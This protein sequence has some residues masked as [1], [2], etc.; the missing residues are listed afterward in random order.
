VY[1]CCRKDN[2]ASDSIGVI[3]LVAVT[4]LLA[5]LVLLMINV[6][7]FAWSMETEIPE[8]FIITAIESI[9]EITGHPDFDSRL[10]LLH[11]GKTNYQN[12]NLKARFFKNGQLVPGTIITMN[13]HDFIGTSHY[14]VQ[15]MG[16]SGC[17]GATW[18]PGER[19][20]ID[21][22]DGTFHPGDSVQVDIIDKNMDVIIS[23]HLYRYE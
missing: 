11:T 18:S 4:I 15:W 3:L 17:S 12:K 19:I 6:Q 5:L 8:I 10:I 7:P 13:G 23:R 20:C 9:D 22:M 2:A 21:F 14:G 1:S 16:G